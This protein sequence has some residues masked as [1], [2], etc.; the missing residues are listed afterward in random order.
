MRCLRRLWPALEAL[1][2]LA[3]V[4]QEWKDRFGEDF[5]AGQELLRLT[6]RRAE[7][8]PC[9]SPGGV[10]CPRRVVDHG[11]GRLVAVCGDRPKRCDKLILTKQDIAVHE[12]DARK[13]CVAVAV[14][15]GIEPVFDEIAGFR[16]TYRLGDYHPL[17]GKRFP[18]FLTIQTD[19]ASLAG[20]ATL[21]CGATES[22]FILLAPTL[23]L[24]DVAITDLLGRRRA[25]LVALADLFERDDT[26]AMVANGAGGL[27]LAEFH[28]VVIPE[29][30]SRGMKN[31]PTPPGAGWGDIVLEFRAEEVIIAACMGIT[32]RVEPEDMGMKNAKNGRPTL[33]WTTL[34]AMARSNGRL[35]CRDPKA[36]DRIKSHKYQVSKKL[37]AY[38]QIE[39]DPIEWDATE[40]NWKAR[41]TLRPD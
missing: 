20:V 25:R 32:R 23:Q 9:P 21:L 14:A 17:A 28:R 15:F 2:G 40:S 13:L 10:G 19:R 22:A 31:F 35:E 5:D 33:Q 38:F 3:A 18:I 36:F 37:R 34:Q 7:A 41:F 26:G 24:V 29:E 6:D 1:P 16:Q 39:D 27:I 30:G 12:L 4:A 11:N 8:Y